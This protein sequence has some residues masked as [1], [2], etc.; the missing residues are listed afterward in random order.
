[1]NTKVE[2]SQQAA[3]P[4]DVA[5]YVL[6][7]AVLV[8]SFY[9][10][11]YFGQWPG[12]LRGLVIADGPGLRG[13]GPGPTTPNLFRPFADGTTPDPVALVELA[14]DIRPP[15]YA[16]T[17]AWQAS[18][19]SGLDTVIAVAATTRPPWLDAVAEQPGVIDATVDDGLALFA[20]S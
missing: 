10:F 2:Q 11:Y 18:A 5:K 6:A 19:L 9:A 4:A 7:A 1:M 13:G 14:L 16:R 17:F 20:G 3:S 15:D 8:A 12:P